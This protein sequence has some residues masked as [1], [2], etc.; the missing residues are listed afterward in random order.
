VKVLLVPPSFRST[1]RGNAVT[2]ERW[3]SNLVR[4]GIAATKVTPDELA[5]RAAAERPDLVHAHHAVHTGRA[6]L[7]LQAGP[8]PAPFVVSLGGTD[9]NGGPDG[10]PDPAALAVLHRAT[11][12]LGPDEASGRRLRAG[13]SDAAPYRVVRR[14]VDVPATIPPPP[15]DRRNLIGLVVGGIRPVKGQVDAVDL[16]AS[17]R[18]LDIALSIR[19]VGPA[20]DADYAR[21]FAA[22][23]DPAGPDRWLGEALPEDMAAH[24]AAADFVLNTSQHEGASNALLEGLAAGRPVAA[25]AVAGNTTLLA[26]APTPAACLFAPDTGIPKLAAWLAALAEEHAVARSARG[27]TAR[28][29]VR[30][31][32]DAEVETDQLLSAYEEVMA[33]PR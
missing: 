17:L 13:Y 25:H 30:R 2:A 6:A 9:L 4:R 28:D 33:N 10:A 18:T 11:L 8:H 32:H 15:P 24:Y 21:R 5:A 31:N 27:E 1:A 14:G 7:A 23:L 26:S 20:V 19:F 3:R 12:I 22:R 16:A 29:F